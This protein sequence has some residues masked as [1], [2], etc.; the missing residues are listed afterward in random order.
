MV[1]AESKPENVVAAKEA[2]VSNYIVQ[3][4]Q[5]RNPA[6]EDGECPLVSSRSDDMK[7]PEAINRFLNELQIRFG[8]SV[9]VHVVAAIVSRVVS[10]QN[11]DMVQMS[12][13]VMTEHRRTLHL[14]PEPEARDRLPAA[15]RGDREST[16]PRRPTN[17][18]PSSRRRP[19]RRTASWTPRNRSKACSGGSIRGSRS[20]SRMRPCASTRA[21]GFQD[22]TGQRINKVIKG[23]ARDRDQG[24]RTGVGVRR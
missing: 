14:H 18:M 17:W 15:G 13:R 9:N 23:P 1:T 12:E 2:G 6:V 20:C 21:C 7:D 8:D 10:S 24:R 22:L 4:L 16:C 5:R 19:R 3:A 11:V